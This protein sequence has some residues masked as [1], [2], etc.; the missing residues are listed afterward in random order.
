MPGQRS[1]CKMLEKGKPVYIEGC[2]EYREEQLLPLLERAV[3]RLGVKEMFI[4]KTVVIKPNLV[5]K[6]DP[7]KGGTTHP[8]MLRALITLL[9][10][11][12]ANRL[13]IAESP[14]GLY[15]AAHMKAV[16]EGCGITK[17][18]QG[19]ELNEDYGYG[20][21]KAPKGKKSRV[22]EVI[23]PIRNAEVIVNLCKMKSHGMLMQ[24]CAAKNFFGVIP[25]VKKFEM[26]ARFPKS[27][28]FAGML[29]DL[30]EVLFEG[31][32]I[33]NI[34]DGIVAM[35][36]NGPTNGSPKKAGVVLASENPFTL[37]LAAA[38]IMGMEQHP[39]LL[40]QGIARGYCPE[41]EKELNYAGELPDRYVMKNFLLPDSSKQSAL[42]KLLTLNNGKYA[43]YLEPRPVIDREKC[44]GCGECLRSCP[45]HTILFVKNKQGKNIAEIV[46]ENC[47][48]CYCCQE[49]CPFDSVKIHTNFLIRTVNKL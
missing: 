34:C 14:G 4:G 41:S 43:K 47:I 15:N 3:C 25:G 33:L 1:G 12:G 44:K 29:C 8:V 16:Y 23:D 18:A 38:Y 6:M 20:E 24:S 39:E 32:K 27:E 5:R 9:K 7:E 17:A 10:K 36:G 46:R 48:K 31:R 49:L 19:A 40:A 26:H 13:I 42:K 45:Q 28:D 37:D 35:E 2:E 30:N 21:V 11:L 22:F